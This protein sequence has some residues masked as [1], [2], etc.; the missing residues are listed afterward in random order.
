MNGV[1]FGSKRS[2]EVRR[3]SKQGNDVLTRKLNME[4]VAY[5]KPSGGGI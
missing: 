5:Y 3:D 1:T 2:G 4:R